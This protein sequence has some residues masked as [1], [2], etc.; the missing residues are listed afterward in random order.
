MEKE[1]TGGWRKIQN[2]GIH[3]LYPSLQMIILKYKETC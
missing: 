2:E 3:N 1:T